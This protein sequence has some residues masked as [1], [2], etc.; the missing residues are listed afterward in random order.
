MANAP[1]TPSYLLV[2]GTTY[3]ST[4]PKYVNTNIY[5]FGQNGNSFGLVFSYPFV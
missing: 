1:D 2:N 5:N 3:T 4:S